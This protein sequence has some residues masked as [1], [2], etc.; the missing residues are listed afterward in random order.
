MALDPSSRPEQ[1]ALDL[2]ALIADG[3]EDFLVA[4][5]NQE[6]VDWLER[7]P[8]WPSGRLLLCGPA[9]SGKSHLC[10]LWRQRSGAEDGT[11]LDT[12]SQ[13]AALGAGKSLCLDINGRV[14]GEEVL[15]HMINWADENGASLLITG[16]DPPIG[17]GIKLP[18]LRSRLQ[19]SSIATVGAPDDALLQAVLV[20]LFS[21]RQLQ[22]SIDVLSYITE[23]TER[24]FAAARSLVARID[25]AAL[26]KGRKLTVPLV[27][28]VLENG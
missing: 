15:L 24:S 11:Q 25:N 19:A 22:P 12:D 23:R 17:W 9:G 10:R 26:A 14:T 5:S 3:E 27:R 6:A 1:L 21:D 28:E 13:I 8:E 20:K 2:P 4:P 18:D 16:I 7:W